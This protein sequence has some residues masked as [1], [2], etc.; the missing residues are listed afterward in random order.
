MNKN[1]YQLF[2]ILQKSFKKILTNE[3]NSIDRAIDLIAQSIQKDQLVHI[4][5]T[6]GH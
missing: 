1:F 4:F 3:E 5:G 6:G 2:D